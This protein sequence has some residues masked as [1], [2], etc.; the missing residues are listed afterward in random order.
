M[1]PKW[2]AATP[3]WLEQWHEASLKKLIER[4]RRWV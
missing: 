4:S 2:N 3:R 1:Q